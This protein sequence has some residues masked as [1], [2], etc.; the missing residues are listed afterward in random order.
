MSDLEHVDSRQE[1]AIDQRALDRSFGIT[2]EERREAAVA[3]EHHDRAVV[4]V[5]FGQWRRGI[6]IGRVQDLDR[7]CRVEGEHLPGAGEGYIQRRFR[8]CIGKQVVMRRVLEGDAG[9]EQGINPEPVED[10]DE[11]GH[12][13]LMGMAENHDVNSPGEERQI[14]PESTGIRGKRPCFR[15]FA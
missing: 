2:G 11:A 8:G 7:R 1:A 15:V 13:V 5:A 9:M 10:V 6:R 12:M 4:D 14:R 3:K